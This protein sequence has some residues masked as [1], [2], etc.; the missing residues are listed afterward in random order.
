MRKTIYIL[1]MCMSAS[2]LSCSKVGDSA[3]EAG[4]NNPASCIL[5]AGIEGYGASHL[6]NADD[7]FGVYGSES[8]N[9]VRYVVE[10]TSFGKDGLTRIYGTGAEG[11]II[12]YYPYTTGG[13]EAVAFGRQPLP[14]VQV[15]RE[16][17][18]DQLKDNTILVAKAQGDTLLFRYECGILHLHMTTDINGKVSTAVLSADTTAVCG[19]LS[20]L[21]EDPA[22]ENPGTEISICGIGRK[23]SLETPLDLRF[24]LPPGRYSDLHVTLISNS[25]SIT[26]PVEATLTIEPK[27]ETKCTISNKETI[28][29]GTDIIIIEGRFDE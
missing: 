28:Y 22:I 24:M 10:T 12:G 20:M 5:H 1:C 14:A 19:D 9:N 27:T 11:E 17:S 18:E 7:C 26:K 2:L 13:Y 3:D 6:W 25:E 23:C 29:N 4:V 15:F 8:G 21:G 16:T